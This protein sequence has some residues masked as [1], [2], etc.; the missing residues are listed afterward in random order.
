MGIVLLASLQSCR[1]IDNDT[2]CKRAL[3]VSFANGLVVV[4]AILGSPVLKM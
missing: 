2:W 4:I 3:I 1:S